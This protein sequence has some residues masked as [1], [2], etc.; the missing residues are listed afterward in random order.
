VVAP[1]P[2]APLPVALPKTF[3]SAVQPLANKLAPPPELPTTNIG[4]ILTSNSG[5]PIIAIDNAPPGLTINKGITDQFV[6]QGA[7][8]GKFSVPY[9]AFV[10]SKQDA[11]IS[12]QAKQGDDAPLPAWV[13]FD[14]QAGTFEV[15]PPA[16]FKGKV[17]LKVVARDDD[18]REATSI[19]RLFIGDET[20][21][22]SRPQSRNS[23]SEK[24]RLAAKRSAVLTSGTGEP[25]VPVAPSLEVTGRPM[26]IE[27]AHAG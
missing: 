22:Q 14:P 9:D 1:E 23:L 10:H 20:T 19:F 8:N 13:R 7:S 5:F 6:E 11:V 21:D 4:D 27:P 2:A 24:I 26:V 12:L 16:N 3:N 15:N 25:A 18:G 17:E